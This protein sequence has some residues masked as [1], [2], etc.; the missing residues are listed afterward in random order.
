MEKN[1]IVATV[2]SA[3]SDAPDSMEKT[4]DFTEL[5]LFFLNKLWIIVLITCVCGAGAYFYSRFTTIPLYKS[6]AKIY[7]MDKNSDKI[8]TANINVANSTVEDSM[9]LIKEEV[10]VSEALQNLA[11]D[12]SYSSVSPYIAVSNESDSLIINVSVSN[13]DPK[14]ACAIVNELCDVSTEKIKN[15]IGIDQVNVFSYGKEATSP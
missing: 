8:N 3:E 10:L 7:L 4:I 11:L 1:E 2:R 15:I 5:L 6:T 12:I 13:A 9:K 14:I